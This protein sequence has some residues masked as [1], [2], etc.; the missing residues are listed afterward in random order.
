MKKLK[1]LLFAAMFSLVLAPASWAATPTTL[2]EW[3]FNVNGTV[4][5]SLFSD[6]LPVGFNAGGFNFTTG[7]GTI[8]ATFTAP[9]NYTILGFFDLEINEA[10]NTFF[11]ELGNVSGALGSGQSYEID[12]PGWRLVNPG[13]IYGNFS[14][15]TLDNSNA[16][17]APDDVSMA[18][19]YEFNLLAGETGVINFTISDVDPQSGFY[20]TQ[21]DQDSSESIYLSSQKTIRDTGTQVPE[22]ASLLLLGIGLLG[23]V[24][25]RKWNA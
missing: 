19:G 11:N 20:L 12:E 22:P 24:I 1:I 14:A 4:S 25:K 10:T 15:G 3:A 9:G 13:D 5:D 21:T 17:I 2:F 16:S 6:P 7:L 18:I 8:S 23:I